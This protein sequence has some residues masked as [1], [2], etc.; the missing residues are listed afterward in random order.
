MPGS[1][2]RTSNNVVVQYTFFET[3]NCGNDVTWV[4]DTTVFFLERPIKN[5]KTR[6]R[7]ISVDCFFI[8]EKINSEDSIK[9]TPKLVES[10][11]IYFFHRFEKLKVF[12]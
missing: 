3:F 8:L 9:Y 5:K 10:V 1:S 12:V 6:Q 4:S 7:K 11:L 2:C